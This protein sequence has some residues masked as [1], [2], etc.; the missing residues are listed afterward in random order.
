MYVWSVKFSAY[1]AACSVHVLVRVVSFMLVG[2]CVVGCVAH[3]FNGKQFC[4][5]DKRSSFKIENIYI[6]R[7]TVLCTSCNLFFQRH[8][9]LCSSRFTSCHT[10]TANLIVTFEVVRQ[11]HLF[12][13]CYE[14]MWGLACEQV[15]SYKVLNWMPAF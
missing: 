14:S 5:L 1:N 6:R 3:S 13:H 9:A 8:A 2:L 7:A 4:Y 11:Q 12:N 10:Y 15:I